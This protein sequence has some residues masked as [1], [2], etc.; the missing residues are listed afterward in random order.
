MEGKVKGSSPWYCLDFSPLDTS[1]SFYWH[2]F[3]LE[4]P[5][6]QQADGELINWYM[7][8]ELRWIGVQGGRQAAATR[9][10]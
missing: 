3:F 1:D 6:V 9:Q 5:L 7:N 8:F 4:A 2:L 10:H